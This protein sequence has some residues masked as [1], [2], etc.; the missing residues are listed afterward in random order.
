VSGSNNLIRKGAINE[1]VRAFLFQHFPK[2]VQGTTFL[3]NWVPTV[4]FGKDVGPQFWYN[5]TSLHVFEIQEVGR[6]SG[7]V[8]PVSSVR[9]NNGSRYL[10]PQ[11]VIYL[12]FHGERLKQ[13]SV[14]DFFLGSNL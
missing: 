11:T 5:D 10:D 6:D 9:T 7:G 12:E 4:G 14:N 8:Y 2:P 13:V 3:F 1:M